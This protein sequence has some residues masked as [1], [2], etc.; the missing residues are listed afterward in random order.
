METSAFTIYN[1][2]SFAN[3]NNFT[4]SFP[5]WMPF[6]SFSLLIAVSGTS[7]TMLNR[8]VRLCILVSDLEGKVLTFSPLS[9]LLSVDLVT[10]AFSMLSYAPSITTLLNFLSQTNIDFFSNSF[11]IY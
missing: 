9:V 7:N 11:L 10:K 8:M 1:I 4:F 5:I 6:T 3:S 2:L